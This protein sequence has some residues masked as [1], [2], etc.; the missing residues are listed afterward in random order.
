MVGW[1]IQ[2]FTLNLRFTDEFFI[3]LASVVFGT[4]NT[5][6]IFLI[7]KTIKDPLTGLYAAFL[8]TAS[9]YCFIISG[10]FIMPDTPQVLFWLLTI[11]LLVK[12]LPD[13][14]LSKSSRLYVI[15][16]GFS[17]GLALL[18]KYH[19]VFLI[20]G[21][22]LYI[23]FFNRS[24]FRAKETYFSFIIAILCFTP[25]LIWNWQ[26][27]FVSFTFHESRVSLFE[28]GIRWDFLRRELLGQ[29]FYNNPANV[30]I[31]IFAF[32]GLIRKKK[33]MD[34]ENLRLILFISLPLYII[35]L[36]FSFF[37]STLPHW[38]GP[39]YIGFILIA[40]AYLREVKW[41]KPISPIL[42]WPLQITLILTILLVSAGVGQIKSGFIP[43][44]RWKTD[45]FSTQLYG[46]RQLGEKFASLAD[47]DIKTGRMPEETPI[48]AFRW[49][50][51]ANLDYYVATPIHKKV[52]ALGT[53][54]RIHKY[55]WINKER[56][57]IRRGSAAYY[58]AFSDE[59]QYP[60]DHYVDLFDSIQPPDTLPIYRGGKLIRNVYIYRL[61]G[62]KKEIRFNRLTDFT[63]P[64][65][66][67]IRYW[68]NQIRTHPDWML[69]LKEKAEARGRTLE[70]QIWQEANWIAEREM[71][72][73]D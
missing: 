18:S 37:D 52:Y 15:L 30:I 50:P 32:T 61:Y 1:I 9:F 27:Q 7:G 44:E 41:K 58:F 24:W 11:L 16:S 71:L 3:R 36:A 14:S 70:D 48:I 66:E 10:T 38:T 57:N 56:G 72:E 49:F 22:F 65:I 19:S 63:E 26:N 51:A 35:F 62:L 42:P 20:T 73:R 29:F 39:A 40:A 12:S 13:R 33:L 59:Y 2:L 43:F 69:Q 34:K 4:V 55:Y 45:D 64:P 67:R 54:A 5:Y 25:V 23:L 46:Y 6:L 31:I 68:Q 28:S 17:I 21:A 8:F 60:P 53:L 47:H